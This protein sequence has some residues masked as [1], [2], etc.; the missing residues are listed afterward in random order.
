LNENGRIDGP[1]VTSQLEQATHIDLNRDV[2]IGYRS[3]ANGGKQFQ[4]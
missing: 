3:S 4:P 2:V 1:G